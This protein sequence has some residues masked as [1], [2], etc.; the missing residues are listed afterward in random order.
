MSVEMCVCDL[1]VVGEYPGVLWVQPQLRGVPL[2]F[3]RWQLRK[4]IPAIETHTEAR[5][6]QREKLAVM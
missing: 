2:P 3:T 1:F 6:A 5:Q 4:L